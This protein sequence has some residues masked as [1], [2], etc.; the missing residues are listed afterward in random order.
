M[1]RIWFIVGLFLLSMNTLQGQPV[2]TTTQIYISGKPIYSFIIQ[3]SP[4][5][6]FTMRQSDE[7]YINGYR[8]YSK[9]LQKNF[10]STL[11]YVI[12]TVTNLFAFGPLTHEEGHRS[13]LISRNIGSIS[14]PFFLSKRGGYIDGVTDSTLKKLR[15]KDF[16]DYAHLY[17]AG[18]ESDYMLTHREESFMAFGTEPYRNLA[19]EYI[20]RK[21]LIMNYYLMGFLK[22]DIDGA[23]ESDELKRDIVGNDVYGV[24]RHLH[25]PDMPF[26][27]YTRY[28]DLTTEEIHYLRTIGFRSL[29]NLGN[30][31]IVGIPNI[32]ITE[33]LD[34]NFGL[35]HTLCPFGDFIDENLWV[36]YKDKLRVEA[37]LREFENRTN[38]FMGGGIG[39][40]EYPVSK[41]CVASGLIHVWNQPDNLGFNDTK[42]KFGKALDFSGHYFFLSNQ[43]TKLK[44]FSVDIGV[45][46]KTNGFL[47][48]EIYLKSHF[49]IRLG[50]SFAIDD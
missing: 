36:K 32:N 14:Q 9:M 23:E 41:R 31:N 8:L 34:I 28:A 21:V 12:Q 44:A 24:I 13:I 6:L 18:L 50:T 1:N 22:Y 49:G 48:E 16:P 33:N 45:I 26:H 40:N 5:R 2:D 4:A 37:Y 35:G 39:I 20:I 19:D 10:S 29:L 7:D 11:N 27:R 42:G 46:Y 30:L 25:R 17:T 15:D 3:D 47:P 38:W 43:K